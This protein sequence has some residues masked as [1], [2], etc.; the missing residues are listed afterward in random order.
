MASHHPEA[1]T[2]VEQ[3]ATAKRVRCLSIPDRRVLFETSDQATI[4]QLSATL[5]VVPAQAFHC[6]CIGTL[7]IE[8]E[9]PAPLTFTVHHGI[10]VRVGSGGE[11]DLL[12]RDSAALMRWLS[13][14]GMPFVQ[15]EHDA[16]VR[17]GEQ[18]RAE[19][20][21]W[22]SRL[23]SSLAPF[24]DEMGRS[25]GSKRTEWAEAVE[26]EY[27]DPVQRARVLLTCSEAE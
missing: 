6:M 8:V 7:N 15:E 11:G 3:V 17:R 1:G 9:G 18:T 27:P 12:L 14:H 10:S 16:S 13:D 24:F 20:E 2:L 19:A 26:A 4:T 25:G 22:R 23:P 5:H 21:R